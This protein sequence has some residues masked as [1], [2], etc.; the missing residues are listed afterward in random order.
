MAEGGV[1]LC[2]VGVMLCH[3]SG[4]GIIIE[5][6]VTRGGVMASRGLVRSTGRKA[7]DCPFGYCFRGLS[8]FSFR[9]VS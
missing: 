6:S 8:R 9:Y 7:S 2:Y 1:S 3:G 4:G 5:G